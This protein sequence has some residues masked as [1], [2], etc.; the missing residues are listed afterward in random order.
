MQ[1]FRH[2]EAPLRLFAGDDCLSV[3]EKELARLQCRRA[4][5]LCGRSL[6]GSEERL[7][8]RRAV[9]DRLAGQCD[10]VRAHSPRNSVEEIATR[11]SEFDADAVVAVGGGSAMVTARA[12]VIAL[13]EDRPLDEL[14][15][16]RDAQ[17]RMKSP[18]LD[19][20]KLPIFAAPTTPSTATVKPGT[21]IYDETNGARIA[22]FDPNTRPQA[23]FLEPALLMTAP[24]DLLRGAALNTLSSAAE[25]L[26]SGTADRMSQAM[27]LQA[28]RLTA[29][30]LPR[31]QH[32]PDERVDLAMAAVLC[33][34]GT[35]NTGLGLA[36]VISHAVATRCDVDP[37]VAKAIALPPVM[38]F[39]RD[40]ITPGREAL[41]FAL[42]CTTDRIEERWATLLQELGLPAGLRDTGVPADLLPE[43]A[44]KCMADW[45][46]RTNPRPVE[47]GEDVLG[48]LKE[49]W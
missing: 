29:E 23:V 19:A 4:V 3:L 10:G 32:G 36:T 21:A 20:P 35:D 12:A 40:F 44:E 31:A 2:F 11:L 1:S 24:A 49:A 39:N 37:G 13:A 47:H 48:V 18:R 34:R 6:A 26:V 7:L 27:L 9:G 14:C 41:A 33:G 42:G 16:R 25:G 45:F 8:V 43:I 15:T 17:G 46:I 5:I 30:I 38:H 22:L 28:I